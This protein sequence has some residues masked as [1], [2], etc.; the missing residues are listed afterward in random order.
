MDRKEE[1]DACTEESC[2]LGEVGKYLL[3]RDGS[4]GVFGFSQEV[5]ASI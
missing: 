1:R 5:L 3:D 2:E 4:L